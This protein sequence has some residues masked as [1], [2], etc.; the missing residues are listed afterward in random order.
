MP[1][2]IA[3]KAEYKRGQG[4]D[5]WG[6]L[7]SF[8]GRSS[9]RGLLG[10]DFPVTVKVGYFNDL[11]GYTRSARVALTSFA[12]IHQPVFFLRLVYDRMAATYLSYCMS[13]PLCVRK[14]RQ[15]KPYISP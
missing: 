13:M 5:S 14:H 1:T 9:L 12:A 15:G 3:S 11:T 10:T 7:K 4:V 6:S 8:T 2:Q